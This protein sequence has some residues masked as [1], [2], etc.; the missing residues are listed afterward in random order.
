MASLNSSLFW[1]NISDCASGTKKYIG[2]EVTHC[3][4]FFISGSVNGIKIWV[5]FIFINYAGARILGK[6][7]LDKNQQRLH[8]CTPVG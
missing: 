7:Y 1:K 5:V 6:T 4:K 8:M 3:A 2:E